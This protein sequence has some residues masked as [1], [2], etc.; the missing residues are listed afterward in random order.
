MSK[1][2]HVSGEYINIGDSKVYYEIIGAANAPVLV[3]LHGGLGNIEDFNGVVSELSDRFSIVGI[4]SRGHG[5][6]TLG[7]Q[8][9]TYELLQKD[10]ELVL[11]HLGI[12]NVTI[13]GS[14]NGGTV[15]YR[16]AALTNLKI[17][18]LITIGAPWSTRCVAHLFD[19]YSKLT[20]DVWKCHCP[21]HF[22]SY[23]RLNPEPEF[24]SL[25]KQA[26]R[27]ALDESDA[28]RPNERVQNI[29]CSSLFV[30][31]DEDP[32]VSSSDILKLSELVRNSRILNVPCEGHEFFKDKPVL[33]KGE[34]EQFLAV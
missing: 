11:K 33:L 27:M 8:K 1:F 26:M 12:N 17:N 29:S 16:L 28:G 23:H 7:S 19:A 3:F 5:K 6:S 4:D 21:E 20:A 13:V 15:A 22:E 30:R 31:G 9:L 34:L 14:S 25:F 10:V 18:K 2:D 32:V 24:G